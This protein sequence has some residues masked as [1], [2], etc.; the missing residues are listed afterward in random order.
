MKT[1]FLVEDIKTENEAWCDYSPLLSQDGQADIDIGF[2]SLHLSF[3]FSAA[4]ADESLKALIITP[5]AKSSTT[6]ARNQS[7]K[8]KAKVEIL[9]AILGFHIIQCP[10]QDN[11]SYTIKNKSQRTELYKKEDLI[12][13]VRVVL[14]LILSLRWS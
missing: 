12:Q 8:P 11:P 9:V 13:N 4:D 6:K 2:W 7:W 14:N 1:K 5:K 10:W 3:H